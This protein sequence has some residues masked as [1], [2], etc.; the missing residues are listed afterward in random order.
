MSS[1]ETDSYHVVINDKIDPPSGFNF[2][3]T[4]NN[5]WDQ[6]TTGTTWT[7]TSPIYMYQLTCPKCK[8][9]NWG[10]IDKIVTCS[11]KIGRKNCFA[12]LKAVKEKVDYEINVE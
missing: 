7:Y 6:W 12:K 4:S 3:T 10:E 8:K 1:G 9:M 5:T 11:G 2:F